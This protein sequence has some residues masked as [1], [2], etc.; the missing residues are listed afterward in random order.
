MD[1]HTGLTKEQAYELMEKGHK[2]SH[3]FYTDNEH[4]K[5]RDGIIYDE[6]NYRMGTKN[7]EFW[8]KYQK[9]ETGWRTF[10]GN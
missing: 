9:W 3:E 5:M 1:I 7:D 8:I 6:N 2:I 10:N 4:L